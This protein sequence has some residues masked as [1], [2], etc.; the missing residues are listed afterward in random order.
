MAT[1]ENLEEL[2]GKI[3]GCIAGPL[4]GI[5]GVLNAPGSALVRVN[6]ARVDEGGGA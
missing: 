4:R 3:V 1:L 6:Q 2:R 5:V